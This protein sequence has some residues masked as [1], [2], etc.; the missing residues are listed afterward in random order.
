MMIGRKIQTLMQIEEVLG[1]EEVDSKEVFEELDSGTKEVFEVDEEEGETEVKLVVLEEAGE[2]LVL[3]E[4]GEILVEEA[5][6]ATE[7]EVQ[8]EG[9][10]KTKNLVTRTIRIMLLLAKGQ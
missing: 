5:L 4:A 2:I 10:I 8:E 1:V 7:E 3:E 6:E 9:E